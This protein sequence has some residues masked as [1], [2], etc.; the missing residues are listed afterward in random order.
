MVGFPIANES[1][2][3][4]DTYLDLESETMRETLKTLFNNCRILEA[5]L[6]AAE[7]RIQSLESDD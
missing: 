4:L 6:L 2:S 5:R 3:D 1:V 7:N